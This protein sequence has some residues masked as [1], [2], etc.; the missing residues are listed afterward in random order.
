MA[1]VLELIWL[2]PALVAIDHAVGAGVR[3]LPLL[4]LLPA[5]LCVRLAV[6]GSHRRAEGWSQGRAHVR[7]RRL[8][9]EVAALLA[10]SV[11]VAAVAR[12]EAVGI[13]AAAGG[14]DAGA[15]ALVVTAGLLLWLLG[16]RLG[17]IDMP[18]STFLGEFQFGLVI[19]LVG[20]FAVHRLRGDL[21]A[22]AVIGPVY[23]V[24]GLVGAS[25]A[26]RGALPQLSLRGRWWLIL[27]GATG[28]V[29]L[30]GFAVTALVTPDVILSIGRGCAWVWHQ[31]ERGF[32]AI[33][34]LFPEPEGHG[35]SGSGYTAPGGSAEGT[36][37]EEVLPES[38]LNRPG[39]DGGSNS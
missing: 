26:R 20:L 6:R 3:V 10:G 35:E 39:F 22:A 27:V 38:V 34:S 9:T 25:L 11:C 1:A 36:V 19:L 13:R 23:V 28:L 7:A 17:S 30:A 18:F 33:G 31:M 24:L 14:L 8:V 29:F 37:G 32:A 5:S 4:A 12:I 21:P 16:T 15:P 2:W